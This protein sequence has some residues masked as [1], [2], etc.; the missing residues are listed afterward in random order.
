MESDTAAYEKLVM[1]YNNQIEQV[2]NKAQKT[3]LELLNI[4]FEDFE[5]SINQQ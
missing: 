1:D 4:K 3:I 2:I 5:E